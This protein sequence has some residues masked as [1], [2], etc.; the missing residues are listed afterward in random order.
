[1]QSKFLPQLW[2]KRFYYSALTSIEK[3]KTFVF[4]FQFCLLSLRPKE[5]LT[6]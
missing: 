3:Y 2:A 6:N 5:I 1:M 4:R